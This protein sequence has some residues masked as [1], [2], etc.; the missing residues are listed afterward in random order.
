L[1]LA[2]TFTV[3]VWLSTLPQGLVTRTQYEVVSFSAEVVKFA[4][5]P[6]ASGKFDSPLAPVNHW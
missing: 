5:V 1:A 6:P 2:E 3:A 4:D